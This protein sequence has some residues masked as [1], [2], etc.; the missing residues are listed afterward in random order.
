MEFSATSTVSQANMEVYAIVDA[1]NCISGNTSSNRNNDVLR[2]HTFF[3]AGQIKEAE[4]NLLFLEESDPDIYATMLL[5]IIIL[6]PDFNGSV[7]PRLAALLS[8]KA[9]ISR[10]WINR[11]RRKNLAKIPMFHEKTKSHIRTALLSLVTCGNMDHTPFYITFELSSILANDRSLQA[12]LAFTLSK[13]VKLDVPFTFHELAPTLVRCTTA[14]IAFDN[15]NK[16]RDSKN[17]ITVKINAANTLEIVLEEIC[18]KRLLVDKEYVLKLSKNRITILATS[19]IHVMNYLSAGLNSSAFLNSD[20]FISVTG[21]AKVLTKIIRHLLLASFTS[22]L[23][24][25]EQNTEIGAENIENMIDQFFS[26]VLQFISLVK[27]KISNIS[28][29]SNGYMDLAEELKDLMQE[30][31]QM[32]IDVQKKHAVAFVPIISPFVV[33][34]HKELH[35]ASTRLDDVINASFLFLAITFLSNVAG[36]AVYS[37]DASSNKTMGIDV[38]KV[39]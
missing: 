30:Q 38:I 15:F 1:L 22:L 25:K 14:T 8:L 36:C 11:A 6:P 32:V 34:F 18:S 16:T 5:N 13:I 12:S 29:S 37:S 26:S 31:C 3:S 10:R 24:S 4:S 19:L 35:C 20:N 23:Y 17:T 7:A 9:A 21:H 39:R 33:F 27:T 2:A 28:V